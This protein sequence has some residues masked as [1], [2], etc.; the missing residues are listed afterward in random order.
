MT[1]L[2]KLGDDRLKTTKNDYQE[3]FQGILVCISY[4][5]IIGLSNIVGPQPILSQEFQNLG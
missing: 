1:A 4:N 2:L 5:N 3:N